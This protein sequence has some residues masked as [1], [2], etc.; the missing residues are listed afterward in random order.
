MEILQSARHDFYLRQQ[1]G[2]SGAGAIHRWPYTR[3]DWTVSDGLR[4]FSRG[5][6]DEA[7]YL[8]E[9]VG[10]QLLHVTF[11]SVLTQGVDSKGRRFKEGILNALHKH[12]D[13]HL[14][15]LEKHFDKHLSGLSKGFVVGDFASG[16]LVEV[17]AL[18]N[19]IRRK[20]G[21]PEHNYQVPLSSNVI[22]MICGLGWLAFLLFEEWLSK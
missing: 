12:P 7:L 17:N 20:L 8:D 6:A 9:R 15:F 10:R 16:F 4:P 13:L 2:I 14:E 3:T 21:K 18:V 5:A 22:L 11:G 19:W 1:Q